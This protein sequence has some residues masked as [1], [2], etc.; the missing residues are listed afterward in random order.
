MSR[1][2]FRKPWEALRDG[3]LTGCIGDAT[4][5]RCMAYILASI[6]K[7]YAGSMMPEL[8][9]Q[10]IERVMHGN[11]DLMQMSHYVDPYML[12]R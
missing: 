12:E 8:R 10:D 6:V 2:V 3:F 11:E 4:Y 7:C 9:P 1:H 5:R